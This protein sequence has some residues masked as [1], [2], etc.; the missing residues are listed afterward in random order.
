MITANQLVLFTTIGLAASVA[1]QDLLWRVEGVGGLI[2]RG[3]DLHRMGDFNN[4]GWE[5]LL[6]EGEFWNGQFR[7]PAM[8]IISGHDGSILSSASPVPHAWGIGNIAP[9]GDMNQ[10]GVLDYGAHIWD[11]GNPMYTQTLAV[12]SGTTH[13]TIWT[14]TIPSAWGT[15]FAGVLAGEFDANG[16]GRND[17]VTSAHSLS[18]L[19]TIIVY[20]NSGTELYR[21]VNPLPNVWVGLDVANLRG[22][23]DGDGCGDFVSSGAD[24]QNRGAIVCFSGRT[25]AV[26]RVSYGEQPGDKLVNAGACGDVDRDGVPDY[27]GGGSFGASVVTAFSGATGQIIHSWRDTVNSAMGT[28]VNGGHDLDQDGVPDLA[29][30]SLGTDMNV[31]SGR[32]GTFLARFPRSAGFNT[33]SGEVLAMLAPPPGEQYPIFVYSERCWGSVT[34][35]CPTNALCPGVVFAYRGCP[36]GV[37]RFGMADASPH[38][39]LA[40][41]GM[42]S[43]TAAATPTVRFT[44]SDAPP[45]VVAILTLGS[46]NASIG[47]VALPL[48]LDPFGFPGI[49]LWTSAD[50]SL[51]TIAGTTGMAAGYAEFDV[52]L[53]PGRTIEYTGTPLYAQW[54]WFDP[55]NLGNHGS[56]AGQRF[57]LQ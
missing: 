14:A 42:R 7:T 25:G 31:F 15:G 5:D 52:A 48:G 53:P 40:R 6:E 30:G 32:D 2:G 41:T 4:D 43:P 29:A 51:L 38:Q 34:N 57:R 46:S 45:G 9:L 12:F 47:S 28:N 33:C 35:P 1:G 11:G 22:D 16:D 8:R 37:R 49:T 56:T 26:L 23:L 44:M 27:C 19:G 21:I 20:D 3:V 39:L 36:K 54:L 18:L 17:V 24:L 50:V 55:T 13:A 10:D